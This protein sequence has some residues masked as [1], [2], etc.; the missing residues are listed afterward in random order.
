MIGN[1]QTFD[2]FCL[3]SCRPALCMK[4]LMCHSYSPVYDT[5]HPAVV[6][7]FALLQQ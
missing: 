2:S 5:V 1:S 7:L 4:I 3:R 6:I